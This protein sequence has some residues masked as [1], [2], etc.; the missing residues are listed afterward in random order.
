MFCTLKKGRFCS[1]DA[2]ENSASIFKSGDL[3]AFSIWAVSMKTKVEEE[4]LI[5]PIESLVFMMSVCA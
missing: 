1:Y 5:Y 3:V 2:F 4:Q